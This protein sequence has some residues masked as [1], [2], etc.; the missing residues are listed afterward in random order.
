MSSCTVLVRLQ[1]VSTLNSSSRVVRCTASA[2][3]IPETQYSRFH[4]RCQEN[5]VTPVYSIRHLR[6]KRGELGLRL[7]HPTPSWRSAAPTSI[8]PDYC[9]VIME[10]SR[11]YWPR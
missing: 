6:N 4:L 2:T 10:A 8:L 7:V 5:I 9:T 3:S 11:N 1:C